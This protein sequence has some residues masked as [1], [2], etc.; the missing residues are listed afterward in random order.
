[1]TDK[2]LAELWPRILRECRISLAHYRA[3]G[4]LYAPDDIAVDVAMVLWRKRRATTSLI[5]RIAR[6]KTIDW[7]RVHGE[8]T[9]DGRRKRIASTVSIEEMLSPNG[10]PIDWPAPE[11]KPE[12]SPEVATKYAAL[13][14]V[15]TEQ[16][17]RFIV[18]LYAEQGHKER[19]AKRLGLHP[20]RVSQVCKSLR[21]A[22]QYRFPQS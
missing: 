11:T 3:W 13:W 6:Y 9:R 14:S 1:M 5:A 15:A 22:F 20:A 21:E 7:M 17:R 19:A 12:S 8:Q 2:V 10:K 4:R 18:A 16:E